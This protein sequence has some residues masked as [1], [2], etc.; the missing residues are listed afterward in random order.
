MVWLLP[1]RMRP[2][3][4]QEALDACQETEMSSRLLVYADH[5]GDK[6]ISDQ[7]A[8]MRLPMNVELR[9]VRMDMADTMRRVFEF[10]PDEPCYGWIADDM[11][12]RTMGWDITLETL[13][14]SWGIATC[15]D[16]YLSEDLATRSGVLCGAQCFGG[17]LVRAVGWWALPGVRQ[18]GIDDA[19]V[20][21][22]SEVGE[23]IRYCEDVIV[24]HWN[25]RTDRRSIDDTDTR[26][27]A[28]DDAFLQKDL[29]VLEEW[30]ADGSKDIIK[31]HVT[32][33]KTAAGWPL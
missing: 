22:G 9:I 8:A 14:A 2:A 32:D 30:R 5:G 28:G 20:T 3:L 31:K 15:R 12:P 27:R 26:G 24:E 10:L 17:E 18:G 19:W 21:L 4:C 16:M 29:S 25:W 7:Y 6:G 33:A 1:T 11:R 23:T 13:A